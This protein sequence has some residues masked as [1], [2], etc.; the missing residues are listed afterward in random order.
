M[1]SPHDTG[2]F[3]YNSCVG[4][5]NG[6]TLEIVS[7]YDLNTTLVS[8]R[9]AM[10]ESKTFLSSLFK[11]NSCVGSRQVQRIYAFLN[12]NLNTTLVSVRETSHALEIQSLIDLNTTLV[13][14]RELDWSK[15]CYCS[16]I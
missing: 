6:K 16:V 3:K 15:N 7:F 5:S 8:V 4:S 9:A 13:S 1:A 2:L 14:V 12:I 11:Y 10:L